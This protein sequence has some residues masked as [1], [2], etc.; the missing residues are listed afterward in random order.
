MY[1]E[2]VLGFHTVNAFEKVVE[3]AKPTCFKGD[4][5]VKNLRFGAIVTDIVA[6]GKVCKVKT[7]FPY[8]LKVNGKAFAVSVGENTF[9]ID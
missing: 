2:Y 4:F 5:G 6:N 7:N 8:T 1:L 3:W 9:L